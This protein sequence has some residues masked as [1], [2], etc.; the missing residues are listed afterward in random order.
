[1]TT[2]HHHHLHHAWPN[3]NKITYPILMPLV[4]YLPN[5]TMKPILQLQTP[6]P[7][8][9]VIIIIVIIII[10]I[11]II[12]PWTPP[13]HQQPPLQQPQSQ[14]NSEPQSIII[15][16]PNLN[17]SLQCLIKSLQNPQMPF[18]NHHMRLQQTWRTTAIRRWRLHHRSR[19]TIS[20]NR[21]ATD[22]FH[23]H[24][25]IFV[26]IFSQKHRPMRNRIRNDIHLLTA[27]LSAA[28]PWRRIDHHRPVSMPPAMHRR[29]RL[30]SMWPQIR[31]T[32]Q[33][34]ARLHRNKRHGPLLLCNR[35]VLNIS[36]NAVSHF[37]LCKTRLHLNIFHIKIFLFIF[38][39]I[40]W[41]QTNKN[42][43]ENSKFS[44]Q[45]ALFIANC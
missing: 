37:N 30:A 7:M 36:L 26:W 21:R 15:R 33:M 29:R 8:R 22:P 12:K 28:Q 4:H 5:K 45:F 14:P 42:L 11:I 44:T 32:N 43:E 35:Y 16:F 41:Q 25:P 40:R 17:K 2:P 31:W 3:T 24:C 6:L 23:R 20:S 34:D 10:V 38:V 13:T 19:Q 9:L 27:V 39:H 1:M 18:V